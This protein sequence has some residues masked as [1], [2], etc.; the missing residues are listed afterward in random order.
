MWFATID[1]WLAMV[2]EMV[3]RPEGTICMAQGY[4]G[5]II[6]RVHAESSIALLRHNKESR[7]QE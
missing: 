6:E 4:V 7:M 3:R 5:M 2:G 1:D